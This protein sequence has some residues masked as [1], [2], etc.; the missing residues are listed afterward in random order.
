M[1]PGTNVLHAVDVGDDGPNSGTVSSTELTG[2]GMSGTVQY[3]DM[4][5]LLIELGKGNDTLT[6][7]GTRANT[8]IRGHAG[9]DVLMVSGDLGQIAE[10][11][12]VQ[13]RRPME[14]RIAWCSN[15]SDTCDLQLDK[16]SDPLDETGVA[17]WG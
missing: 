14:T 3:G 12:V 16:K 9:D 4:A 8:E 1:P 15:P 2:L 7:L 17:R 5:E 10:A 13:G 11:A 6:V